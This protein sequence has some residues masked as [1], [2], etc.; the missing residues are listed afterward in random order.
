MTYFLHR[1]AG[2]LPGLGIPRAAVNRVQEAYLFDPILG[3]FSAGRVG[4]GG[5]AREGSG[6]WAG[7]PAAGPRR[8]AGRAVPGPAPEDAACPCENE[9]GVNTT[10]WL[11]VEGPSAAPDKEIALCHCPPPPRL[12]FKNKQILNS[13]I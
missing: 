1:E 5:R 9:G 10:I 2:S 12:L 13:P 4:A 6:S 8:R 3:G 7:R 11:S